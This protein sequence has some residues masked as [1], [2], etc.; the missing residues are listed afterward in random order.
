MDRLSF[1]S[2]ALGVSAVVEA[3]MQNAAAGLEKQK[4]A[5]TAENCSDNESCRQRAVGI[6]AAGSN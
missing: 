3:K 6:M 5:G 4:V 2:V 1:G